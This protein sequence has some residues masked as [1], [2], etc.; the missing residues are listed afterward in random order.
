[1]ILSDR[2]IMEV[3]GTLGEHAQEFWDQV[4]PLKKLLKAQHKQDQEQWQK[5]KQEMCAD[6]EKRFP[7][8]KQWREFSWLDFNTSGGQCNAVLNFH[9]RSFTIDSVTRWLTFDFKRVTLNQIQVV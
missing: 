9:L 3:V 6:L 8:I 7:E 4:I 2:E 5:Q 1:M